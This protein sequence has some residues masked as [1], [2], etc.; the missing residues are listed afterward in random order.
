MIS[1]GGDSVMIILM[2]IKQ[3]NIHVRVFHGEIISR[4]IGGN[5]KVYSF[6]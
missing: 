2:A 6:D 1:Y 4:I 3:H 5:G